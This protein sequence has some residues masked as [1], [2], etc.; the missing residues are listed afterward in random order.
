MAKTTK[1]QLEYIAKY[2][3]QNTKMMSFKI[4]MNTD[5][6]IYEKLMSLD[7]RQGYIKELIRADL[8]REKEEREEH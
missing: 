1:S 5:A 2:D 8:Q 6:D 3:K 7:N 4:N